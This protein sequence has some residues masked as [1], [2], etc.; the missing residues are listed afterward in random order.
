MVNIFFV[1]TEL[2]FVVVV[3]YS[4]FNMFSI[5]AAAFSYNLCGLCLHRQMVLFSPLF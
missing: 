4:K 1:L 5:S 2:V 3:L